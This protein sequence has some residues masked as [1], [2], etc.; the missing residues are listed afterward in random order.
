[1]PRTFVKTLY[2]LSE[3]ALAH[4][5]ISVCQ[6]SLIE[7]SS[8]I[9]Y[10]QG[11]NRTRSQKQKAITQPHLSTARQAAKTMLVFYIL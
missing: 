2:L 1:M 7:Q 4:Q 5:I 11:T 6:K 3:T 10:Q 9:L 8:Y